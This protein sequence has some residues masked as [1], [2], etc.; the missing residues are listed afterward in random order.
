MTQLH[1]GL[2]L[3]TKRTRKREFLDEMRRVV[4]WSRLIAL[5]EPQYPKGKIGR[6]P[7]PVA[8]MLQIRHHAR[9]DHYANANN[10]LEGAYSGAQ[11]S[12]PGQDHHA[13][14]VIDLADAY[15]GAQRSISLQMPAIDAQ[16]HVTLQSRNLN[17]RIPKGVRAGQHLRLAGQGGAGVGGGSAGD[18]YL[19]ITFREHPRFRVDG[20]DVSLD[21]PVAPWE[22][23]LGA[24]V[25]VPTP[26]GSVEMT[27]PA[28]S[29]GGRRLRLKGK[30]IPAN[31]PGNLYVVLNIVLPPA[32]TDDAKAAY[33]TM[34]QTFNFDPRAEFHG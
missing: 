14:V 28:G 33:D 26:E 3:S 8:T 21:V 6:P 15:R 5:I 31:P 23:A 27:V 4:P 22:A 1:L 7:F 34:R 25:T 16:G 19:E 12:A 17:V 18:L 32:D 9:S 30:G 20:R 11:F 10:D 24:E 13:K 2:D 29:P